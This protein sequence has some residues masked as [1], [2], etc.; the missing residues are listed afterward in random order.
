MKK[1]VH[2]TYLSQD[3][4]SL[5]VASAEN[6]DGYGLH[7]DSQG[8]SDQLQCIINTWVVLVRLGKVQSAWDILEVIQDK[9]V[10]LLHVDI[11]I[12]RLS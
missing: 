8:I 12:M 5:I 11:K 4:E 10:L 3:E 2:L 9:E 6:E 1:A 7:L